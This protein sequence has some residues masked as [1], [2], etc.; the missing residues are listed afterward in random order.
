MRV[1]ELLLAEDFVGIKKFL[2]LIRR[3]SLER[4]S[5]LAS[6]CLARDRRGR[7]ETLCLKA[8]E[9]GVSDHALYESRK[10][11]L[12]ENVRRCLAGNASLCEGEIKNRVKNISFELAHDFKFQCELLNLCDQYEQIGAAVVPARLA[13]ECA[14]SSTERA[15]AAIALSHLGDKQGRSED[16]FEYAR[17][18][19]TEQPENFDILLHLARLANDLGKQAEAEAAY[20]QALHHAKNSSERA[21]AALALSHNL[22]VARKIRKALEAAEVALSS[23]PANTEILLQIGH[24]RLRNGDRSGARKVIRELRSLVP[25]DHPSLMILTARSQLIPFTAQRLWRGIAKILR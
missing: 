20:S 25:S 23:A 22:A 6:A 5:N 2:N 18:A 15:K 12:I 21:K 8:R 24:L 1:L 4:S 3:Q 11:G 10:N 13:F 14:S 7:A 19:Q 16:A 9:S 17:L